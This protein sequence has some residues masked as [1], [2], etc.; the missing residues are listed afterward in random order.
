MINVLVNSYY[1]TYYKPYNNQS[2]LLNNQSNDI[3]EYYNTFYSLTYIVTSSLYIITFIT[4][5]YTIIDCRYLFKY[6][7][8]KYLTL[9][10]PILSILICKFI[11]LLIKL[12]KTI[13]N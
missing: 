2:T 3:I 8:L 6:I 7:L 4:H 1:F 13:D 11:N 9:T 10:V 12:L 5:I